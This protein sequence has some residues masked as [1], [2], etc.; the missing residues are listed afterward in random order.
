MSLAP[1]E[2][3]PFNT[4]DHSKILLR[5]T[6]QSNWITL[7]VPF[8]CTLLAVL[9][10]EINPWLFIIFL[11]G[12]ILSVLFVVMKI[13][14]NQEK[15]TH[16]F[17]ESVVMHMVKSRDSSIQYEPK[18]FFYLKELMYSGLL[19]TAP[20]IYKAENYFE[21]KKPLYQVEIAWAHA[22][23]QSIRERGYRVPRQSASNET[24]IHGLFYKFTLPK[25]FKTNVIIRQDRERGLMKLFDENPEFIYRN[26]FRAEIDH[27][28]FEKEFEVYAQD[29]DLAKKLVNEELVNLLLSFRKFYHSKIQLSMIDNVIYVRIDSGKKYLKPG[30][31]LSKHSASLQKISQDLDEIFYL[32][33]QIDNHII[34]IIQ[35]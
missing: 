5:K 11:L 4:I 35:A 13:T 21:Q 16:T 25:R 34:K 27:Q 3:S 18:S 1:K 6:I 20:N 30:F 7:S 24:A 32:P 23:K 9:L 8:I 26:F 22:Y 15:F 14:S 19:E 17:R 31:I 10:A 29:S 12:A 28:A 33:N 2:A